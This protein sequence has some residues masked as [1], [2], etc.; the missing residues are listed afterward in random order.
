MNGTRNCPINRNVMDS[1]CPRCN[2]TEDWNHVMKCIHAEG[3]RDEYLT[4][5]KNKIIKV[6]E[7]NEDLFKLKKL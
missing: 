2:E 5:L 6:D 7:K 3:Q 4:K 1:S